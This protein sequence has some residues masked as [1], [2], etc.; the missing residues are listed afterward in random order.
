M[1]KFVAPPGLQ[2]WLV[3]VHALRHLQSITLTAALRSMHREPATGW[4]GV[5]MRHAECW[6][7]PRP[8]GGSAGEAP[9]GFQAGFLMEARDSWWSLHPLA[10]LL[11]SVYSLPAAP[12][13]PGV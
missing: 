6:G 7:A 5:W 2:P 13:P 8:F 9:S 1:L 12:H 3:S 11:G 4:G 10:A